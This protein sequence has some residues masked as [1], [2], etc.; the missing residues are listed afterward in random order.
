MSACGWG[1][2]TRCFPAASFREDAHAYAS[3]IANGPATALRLMKRNL[4][5]GALQGLRESLAMEAQH[6][7]LSG[8][9]EDAN[10]AISAFV[11]K[12]APNFTFR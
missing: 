11:A 4:N 3:K 2:S 6:M 8:Q 5:R 12:R 7:V 10:E 9:S 1:W